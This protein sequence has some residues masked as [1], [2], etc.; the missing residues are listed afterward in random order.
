MLQLTKYTTI[1]K[2]FFLIVDLFIVK[3]HH[4]KKVFQ[5]N[6]SMFKSQSTYTSGQQA[7]TYELNP[8]GGQLLQ[9]LSTNNGFHN[10]VPQIHVHLL[11]VNVTIFGAFVYP[12]FGIFG[13][14]LLPTMSTL[15]VQGLGKNNLFIYVAN[16]GLCLIGYF[17]G[18][19][20]FKVKKAK[21]LEESWNAFDMKRIQQ[22]V[23]EGERYD[24]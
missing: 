22:M 18:F 10:S 24:G 13:G 1:Q 9:G 4:E 14:L 3:L 5:F 6:L 11:P 17:I 21:E 7:I 8:L 2:D 15:V 19:Y 12:C 23:V 20:F 16:L